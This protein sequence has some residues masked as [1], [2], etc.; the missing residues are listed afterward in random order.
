[1]RRKHALCRRVGDEGYFADDRPEI[2]GRA[3]L[4][5]QVGRTLVFIRPPGGDGPIK[6]KEKFY[7][8]WS[9][10]SSN[11][12]TIGRLYPDGKFQPLKTART[13]NTT[14]T[15]GWGKALRELRKAMEVHRVMTE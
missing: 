11:L 14:S 9:E 7:R 2:K 8:I 15:P 4:I 10:V 6:T 1:V 13:A 3:L 5:Q 12:K